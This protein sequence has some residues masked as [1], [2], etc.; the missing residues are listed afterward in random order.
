M[1][2]LKE[3]VESNLSVKDIIL[4]NLRES[5]AEDFEV[6]DRVKYSFKGKTY[7]GKI[8]DHF[9]DGVMV[10]LKSPLKYPSDSKAANPMGYNTDISV[11]SFE[12]YDGETNPWGSIKG[13]KKL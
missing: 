10:V 12:L 8:E 2:T 5:S 13:L 3:L 7:T 4:E 1:R 6:G 9:G 11:K